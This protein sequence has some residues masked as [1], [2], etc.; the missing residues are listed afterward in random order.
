[1]H[2]EPKCRWAG[3]WISWLNHQVYQTEWDTNYTFCRHGFS[4]LYP[5]FYWT[6]LHSQF[7]IEANDGTSTW[8]SHSI[9]QKLS[10]VAAISDVMSSCSSC[11]SGTM[12]N[13]ASNPNAFLPI[14][15]VPKSSQCLMILSK[16][17]QLHFKFKYLCTQKTFT[18]PSSW[19][20]GTSKRHTPTF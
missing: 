12:S 15:N 8:F 18:T 9:E 3:M 5:I 7:N 17:F 1:M 13:E 2:T 19:A 10:C 11:I 6:T 14:Q 20:V 16:F 4:F